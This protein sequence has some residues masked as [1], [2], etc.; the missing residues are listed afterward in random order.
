MQFTSLGLKTGFLLSGGTLAPGSVD[1]TTVIVQL[2]DTDLNILKLDETIAFDANSSVVTLAPAAIRDVAGNAIG[3][4]ELAVQSFVADTTAPSL[5]SFATDVERG[6]LTLN[7]DEPVRAST[8]QAGGLTLQLAE[9]GTGTDPYTLQDTNVSGGNGLSLTLVLSFDDLNRIKQ[10]T[11][12]FRN[13]STS[14]VSNSPILAKDMALIGNPVA[15]R[16]LDSGLAASAFTNDATRPTL[17][18]FDLNL[19]VVPATL[20]LRF[21]EAMQSASFDPTQLTLQRSS[22]V[23]LAD[24]VNKY[25]LTGGTVSNPNNLS[26]VPGNSGLDTDVFVIELS[27]IDLDQLRLRR[28]GA[29]QNTCF[30]TALPDMALDMLSQQLVPLLNNVNALQVD[31]L[32]LDVTA[33][34]LVGYTIDLDTGLLTFVFDEPVD[35]STLDTSNIRLQSAASP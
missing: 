8:L 29:S 35:S 12:L 7:F 5:V 16:A 20:T 33:P 14:F 2:S 27:E 17:R 24:T 34:R 22:N 15:T 30:I 32:V 31:G 1:G 28:I 6:T 23:P 25:T 26:T 19:N 18:A 3:A 21:S 11:G 13:L 9:N 4:T 10:H